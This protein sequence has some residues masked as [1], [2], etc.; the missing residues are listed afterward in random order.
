MDNE[1]IDG[2]EG[3]FDLPSYFPVLRTF[4]QSEARCRTASGLQELSFVAGRA[5]DAPEDW[6]ADMRAG[7]TEAFPG[8]RPE[9]RASL[10]TVLQRAFD[11]GV[12]H[13]WIDRAEVPRKTR[14][15]AQAYALVHEADIR[16]D[17]ERSTS[18]TQC[19]AQRIARRLACR[20][21]IDGYQAARAALDALA[22]LGLKILPMR[23]VRVV[24][25]G[26]GGEA[27]RATVNYEGRRDADAANAVMQAIFLK[28]TAR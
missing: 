13:H 17:C 22:E 19:E 8:I 21:P 7:V 23:A 18:A 24:Q 3:D 5:G 10:E 14:R 15:L 27:E 16:F 26:W 11:A 9:R 1:F 2:V 4:A 20:H 12:V 28:A 25:A 6:R